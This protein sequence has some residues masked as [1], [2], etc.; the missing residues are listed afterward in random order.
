MSF[1]VAL[2]LNTISYFKL[3]FVSVKRV[4][5]DEVQLYIK[6]KLCVKLYWVISSIENSEQ[7]NLFSAFFVL[8]IA[9]HMYKNLG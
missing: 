4:Q 9:F 5:N 1:G 3:F 8:K 7:K 6:T 2:R